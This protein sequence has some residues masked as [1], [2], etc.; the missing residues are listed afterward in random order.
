M[1][2]SPP[3]RFPS[4]ARPG[5]AAVAALLALLAAGLLS[6]QALGGGPDPADAAAK[7]ARKGRVVLKKGHIDAASARIVGGRLRTFIKDATKANGRVRW[8]RPESAIVRLTERARVKLPAGM[9][10]VGRKGQPVWLIPQVQK[11]GVIWAGWNTEEIDAGQISGDVAWTLRK[12]RGPGKLVVFQTGSFGE[13]SVIFNS[14]KRLP[15]RLAIPTGTHAHGNWAF[16][17]KGTY[18]MRYT[19]SARS[20]AGKR[21]SD[22]GTLTFRVG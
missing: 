6:W 19:M 15:Q 14:R 2:L 4:R 10:F 20:A 21:L 3:N 22:T 17:R 13:S 5:I 7:Q 9:G 18:R 1:H 16:T 8:R 11:P 12:V